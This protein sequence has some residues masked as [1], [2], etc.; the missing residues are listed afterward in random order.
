MSQLAYPDG[1][2]YHTN[3]AAVADAPFLMVAMHV[4]VIPRLLRSSPPPTS[5]N[6]PETLVLLLSPAH[7]SHSISRPS[8]PIVSGYLSVLLLRLFELPLRCA[9]FQTGEPVPAAAQAQAQRIHNHQ[10]AFSKSTH[11]LELTA[12]WEPPGPALG[13]VKPSE[14]ISIGGTD[15]HVLS[16]E[17]L[18]LLCRVRS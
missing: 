18:S 9:G 11:L 6:A 15:R 7:Y 5:A 12:R 4:R 1:L 14:T 17:E 2:L 10:T 16:S 3:H 8:L 13:G